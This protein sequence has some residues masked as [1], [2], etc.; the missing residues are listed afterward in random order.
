M[1][2]FESFYLQCIVEEYKYF[3]FVTRKKH[4]KALKTCYF[5]NKLATKTHVKQKMD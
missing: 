4:C 1:V 5:I 3:L 2:H